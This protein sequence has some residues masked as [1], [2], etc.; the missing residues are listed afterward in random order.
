MSSIDL[1]S[2][3]LTITAAMITIALFLKYHRRNHGIQPPLVPYTIPWLGSAV[4]YNRGPGRFFLECRELYGPVFRVYM[5]GQCI[6]IVSTP[7]DIFKLLWHPQNLEVFNFQNISVVAGLSNQR[8]KYLYEAQKPLMRI[9]A[10]ELA[11]RQGLFDPGRSFSLHFFDRLRSLGESLHGSPVQQLSKFVRSTIHCS[12][13]AIFWGPL[14]PGTNGSDESLL[15]DFIIMDL[16]MRGVMTGMPAIT[17][18]RARTRLTRRFIKYV[19]LAWRDDNQTLDGGSVIMSK[20]VSVYKAANL[21]ENEVAR[22][23]VSIHWALAGNAMNTAFWLWSYLLVD[24]KAFIKV[25][26]EILT[27]V[28]TKFGNIESLLQLGPDALEGSCFPTLNSSIRETLRMIVLPTT[29]RKVAE[30]TALVVEGGQEYRL[31]AGDLVILDI[32]S[33]HMSDDVFPE[34]RSFKVDRFNDGT[35]L[36]ATQQRKEMSMT[37]EFRVFAFGGGEHICRGRKL[38]LHVLRT[39]M[40]VSVALFDISLVQVPGQVPQIPRSTEGVTTIRPLNDLEIS[41]TA[42]TTLE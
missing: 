17:A 35:E 14:L 29:V 23:L 20:A 27:A 5:G 3:L 8:A 31:V 6:V 25:R 18:R 34:P 30:D 42:R 26:N 16:G 10:H 32:Q 11:T 41:L 22:L 9:A 33:M 40:V 19:R 21:D 13:S 12:L 37:K 15:E 2:V 1:Q 36:A 24:G 28:E 39:M 7:A 38:A 4:K